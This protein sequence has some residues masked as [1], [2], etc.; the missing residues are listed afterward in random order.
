MKKQYN[1]KF[2]DKWLVEDKYKFWVQKIDGDGFKVVA[3]GG[4]GGVKFQPNLT[5]ML[6]ERSILKEL[7]KMM[8]I[9]SFF[10]LSLI[11][12]ICLHPQVLPVKTI[13]TSLLT[14]NN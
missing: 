13:H 7:L 3:I 14:R 12:L 2:Q 9:P 6:K 11:L 5:A 8:Q 4:G 1:C 10:M